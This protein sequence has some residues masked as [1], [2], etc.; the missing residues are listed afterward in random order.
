MSSAN[1]HRE[2]YRYTDEDEDYCGEM[3]PMAE[4]GRYWA[5]KNFMIVEEDET[6]HDERIGNSPGSAGHLSYGYQGCVD[7]PRRCCLRQQSSVESS[8]RGAEDVDSLARSV[9]ESNSDRLA[10][11]ENFV[12]T[13]WAAM[14]NIELQVPSLS[15]S[16]HDQ[17]TPSFEDVQKT[18]EEKNIVRFQKKSEIVKTFTM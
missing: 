7:D 16:Q 14:R 10:S 15:S 17:E 13:G 1:Y 18:V 8:T 9:G 4:E 5:H 12:G 3:S 2:N 11:N 6:R